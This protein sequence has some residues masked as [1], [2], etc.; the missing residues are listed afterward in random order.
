MTHWHIE[1]SKLKKMLTRVDGL[2]AADQALIDEIN[3]II[4]E[5]QLPS[6]R[7]LILFLN[8]FLGNRYPGTQL[9]ARVVQEVVSV[10][11]GSTLGFALENSASELGHDA[12]MFGRRIS[13]GPGRCDAI[14]RGWVSPP[15]RWVHPP[16][17]T[18]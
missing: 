17:S 7:E 13:T 12:A 14:P 3:A 15:A 10:N 1:F 6:E 4:G 9:P 8:S 18:L 11:L 16:P 5:R 2:L